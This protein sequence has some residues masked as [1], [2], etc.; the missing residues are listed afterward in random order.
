MQ[1]TAVTKDQLIDAL[2]NLSDVLTSKDEE[3]I[4]KRTLA[5]DELARKASP[6]VL[7]SL[8]ERSLPSIQ[9]VLDT[10][11]DLVQTGAKIIAMIRRW[12]GLDRD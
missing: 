9:E 5:V 4:R 8:S 2:V 3:E 6:E 12:R 7:N 1:E 10:A 11:V